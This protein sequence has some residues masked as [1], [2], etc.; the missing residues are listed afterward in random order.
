MNITYTPISS[1]I[2]EQLFL[3]VFLYYKTEAEW[4]L[5][6]KERD[7]LHDVWPIMKELSDLFA[8][9]KD[10]IDAYYLIG[11]GGLTLL[12]EVYLDMVSKGQSPQTVEDVHTAC[13][14]LSEEEIQRHV[15][16]LINTQIEHMSGDMDFWE[17][18]EQS[19]H[20]AEEKWYFSQFYRN[21]LKSMAELVAL[22]RELVVLYQPYLE[23]GRAERQSFSETFSLEDF[24][25]TSPYLSQYK[26]KLP[27]GDEL[28]DLYIMSPWLVRFA[29]FMDA[30]TENLRQYYI[31]SC[32]VDKMMSSRQSLDDD[33][34]T[35]TLKVMSDL[36]R[37]NVLAALTKPHA[38]SKDIAEALNIT[39]AA[40]SFHTQKLINAQL[41]LFNRED[42]DLK[43]NVNQG[44][45]KEVIAKLQND[46]DIEQS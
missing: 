16:N 5:T 15:Y 12:H 6:N 45:I 46:F 11:G 26:Q 42:K 37:Y 7:I 18:L 20:K 9:Y 22:S 1:E 19:S 13:L 35:N 44:L 33:T 34:F 27:Q 31:V 4:D 23:K 43:Y 24:L 38:K 39:G 32:R 14:A 28:V 8:P 30:N 17:R 36:T 29:F 3:S 40:V 10:R 25:R 2:M 41:L 21:S